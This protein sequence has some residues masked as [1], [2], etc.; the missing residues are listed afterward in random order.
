MELLQSE[1]RTTDENHAIERIQSLQEA[2]QRGYLRKDEFLDICKW[3]DPRQLRRKDWMSHS[4]QTIMD[5]S[6]RAF[7]QSEEAQKILWLC[8]LKG[9]RI[10]IASAI[11]TLCYPEQYGVIDIR[12]WQLLYAY[13][14]VDYDQQGDELTILHWLDY[15]PKLRY[16]ARSF[17]TQ[18]RLIEL[19]L[20]E[21]HKQQQEGNLYKS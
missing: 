3:K 9:V 19:T 10:P 16:W 11:L 14:E 18:T 6:K 1:L 8:R 2:R 12:I 20:F 5:M 4:D 15:L 21:H 7:S 13:G 17:E